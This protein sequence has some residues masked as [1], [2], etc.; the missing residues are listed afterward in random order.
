MQLAFEA[1][2]G[3]FAVAAQSFAAGTL[4]FA[5]QPLVCVPMVRTLRNRCYCVG[6]ISRVQDGACDGR[7]RV[8][9][10][11]CSA[12]YCSRECLERNTEHHRATGECAV[13][14]AMMLRNFGGLCAVQWDADALL[15]TALVLA[16]ARFAGIPLPRAARGARAY[17]EAPATR[18]EGA[19]AGAV[20]AAGVAR[21]C[22]AAL[23]P[24][25]AAAAA[26]AV[27]SGAEPLPR[28]VADSEI[29]EIVADRWS[30]PT[31]LEFSDL[32]TNAS[33]MS[34]DYLDTYVRAH[35][36]YCAIARAVAS[37]PCGRAFAVE[38]DYE[39]FLHV[40]CAVHS[41]S[42]GHRDR[43]GKQIGLAVYP[44]ASYF[45]HCCVGKSLARRVLGTGKA[46][47]F[48]ACADI[49]AGDPLTIRY[50]GHGDEPRAQRRQ[51]LYES[52][53][54]WCCCPKC[55]AEAA[56]DDQH[57]AGAPDEQS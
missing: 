47:L 20:S 4:A 32:V 50:N 11:A 53:N 39:F 31:F 25:V 8:D 51:H 27:D 48:F 16:R 3:K 36:A 43:H 18:R 14:A 57:T 45:N 1:S 15:L 10:A 52:Y 17:E 24:E 55:E 44:A 56:D 46:A 21:E 34:D 37:A 2:R 28:W 33:L 26:A 6:C 42:F 29:A 35:R 38:V 13:V 49:A 12:T 22:V 9:C 40:A 19:H 5:M 7:E 41:N 30:V 23:F 54:F